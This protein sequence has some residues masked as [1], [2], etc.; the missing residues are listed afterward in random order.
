MAGIS[1]ILQNNPNITEI[2]C[3]T[4]SPKLGGSVDISAFPN[5]TG[6]TCVDNGITLISGYENNSNLKLLNINT[7]NLNGPLLPFT[8]NTSLVNFQCFKNNITGSI[9]NLNNSNNWR[10]LSFY[11]NKLS[12]TLP[13]SLSNQTQLIE[14]YSH[15][16]F[17]SGTVPNIDN[18]TQLRRFIVA[19]NQLSESIP[20]LSNNINLTDCWFHVNNFT[21]SIPTPPTTSSLGDYWFGDNFLSGIIPNLTG[22]P[23]LRRFDCQYQ[24]GVYKISGSIPSLSSNI[25]LNYFHC[26]GNQLTGTI[27]NLSNNTFLNF[28]WCGDNLLTGPI[29]NLSQNTGLEQFY[30]FSNCLT[31]TIPSLVGLNNLNTFWCYNQTS[32]INS[33]FNDLRGLTKEAEPQW[34]GGIPFGWSG[35]NNIYTIYNGIGT[36]NYVANIKQLSTGPSVNSFRQNLGRLPITSNIELTFTLINSFPAFG[37]PILNAAIYDSN[38]NNLATSSYTTTTSGTFTLTG[39]AIPANTNI[40]VGFW[41]TAGNPALDNVSYYNDTVGIRGFEGSSVSNTLGDFRANDNRLNSMTVNK[42]L[43]AFVAA[44]RTTG[45]PIVSGV[46]IL[47]LGGAG[48]FRPTGQGITDVTTLRNRGWTVTTGIL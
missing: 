6:F 32:I 34:W 5:L 42:I 14:F 3:G 45:T 23:S 12:G 1:L 13:T 9:P 7:N 46:C 47:N 30:C 33:N 18:L 39:V 25:F 36:N 15:L 10:V 44:G 41:A 19:S 31:G 17:I 43:S 28:F 38:Y 40:I 24:K 20:N 4:S 2:N 16:N 35:V 48:N 21:G 27:P 26:G 11:E 22:V 37:T 29:P 8:N